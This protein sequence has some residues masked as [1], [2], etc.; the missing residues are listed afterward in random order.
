MKK[1]NVQKEGI[2]YI[3]NNL[4]PVMTDR[5]DTENLKQ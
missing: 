4:S 5:V 2:I 1:Q 3:N